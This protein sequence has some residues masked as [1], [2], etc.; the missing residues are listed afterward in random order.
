MHTA[1]ALSRDVSSL[2]DRYE[3]LYED[4]DER[5]AAFEAIRSY[6]HAGAHTH[7]TLQR[8]ARMHD[9]V[10]RLEERQDVYFE[11][12]LAL[13]DDDHTY[14]DYLRAICRI[15]RLEIAVISAM[16]RLLPAAGAII[17]THASRS[18]PSCALH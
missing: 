1:S 17:I 13:P 8:L 15:M 3:R 6:A 14:G 9:I 2:T 16:M 12:Y 7:P 18:H 4:F 5:S 11:R 10:T